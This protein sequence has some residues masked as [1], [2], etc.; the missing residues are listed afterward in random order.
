MRE[1]DSPTCVPDD[2]RNRLGKG[3]MATDLGCL[4]ALIAMLL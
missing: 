3:A 1:D 2:G 4:T